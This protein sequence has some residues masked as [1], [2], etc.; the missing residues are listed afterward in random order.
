MQPKLSTIFIGKIFF[1]LLSMISLQVHATN[2]TSNITGNTTWTLV[3][4]P[5]IL[6]NDISVISGKT[7]TIQAGVEVHFPSASR[8]L[9][10]SGTLI[11]QGTSSNRVV[12]KGTHTTDHGGAV[13]FYNGSTGTIS[14]TSFERMADVS[15]YYDAAVNLSGGADVDFN[16]C[17]FTNNEV[18]GMD[19][20]S[21]AIAVVT[22][23]TFKT[24]EHTIYMPTPML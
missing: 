14:Y 6:V 16:Q 9:Y 8:E 11:S 17:R 10:I 23:S 24:T 19:M 20:E 3:G 22:N 15:S 18:N 5:Y 2:V 21:N 7:L 1:I 12:F 13:Q 4:S